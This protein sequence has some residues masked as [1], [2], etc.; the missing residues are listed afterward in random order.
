MEHEL[1]LT[2]GKEIAS[3]LTAGN[4]ILTFL[5]SQTGNRFTFKIVKKD[6]D[7]NNL[8]ENNLFWVKVLTGSDNDSD[9][10]FIGTIFKTKDGT[11]TYKHSNKS[12]IRYSAQSAKV[13]NWLVGIG[14]GVV[15]DVLKVY[16]NGF[17]LKC[18]K[19]LTVPESIESG[20][21]PK[22]TLSH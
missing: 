13:I 16:H 3:V 9:W 22:C 14:E 7:K 8:T 12:R 6:E 20:I 5:N 18:G 2:T 15:P 4:A 17:C 11:I 19:T 10:T 1:K 21:G